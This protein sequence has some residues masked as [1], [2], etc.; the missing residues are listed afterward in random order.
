MSSS[1]SEHFS[2]KIKKNLF[3]AYYQKFI[4]LDDKILLNFLKVY[5]PL[6]IIIYLMPYV[7]FGSKGNWMIWDNLDSNY[8]W[9]KILLDSG[10][11]FYPNN[12]IIDQPLGGIPRAFLGSEPKLF[13][14]LYYF[15]GP[16][17]T[18]ILN[19][20]LITLFGFVGMYLLLKKYVI[21]D[22]E[23]RVIVYSVSLFF[24]ILPFWPPGGM[25]IAGI[26]LVLYKILKI[27]SGNN[28]FLNWFV[29]IFYLF[30]SNFFI[31]GFFFLCLLILFLLYDLFFQNTF[32][33]LLKVILVIL[34]INILINYRL[35]ELFIFQNE[36]VSN[37]TEHLLTLNQ[38]SLIDLLKSFVRR[39]IESHGHSQSLHGI[40]ILPIILM[41][42]FFML[43]KSLL[44][45][46][47]LLFLILFV[48]IIT[49][50]LN[51]LSF[52]PFSY[53]N[54]IFK[55]Y[56]YFDLARFTLL[57]PLF[58]MVAFALV[59]SVLKK[60]I[61]SS[62]LLIL[63]IIFLQT[64]LS[65]ANHEFFK[66]RNTPNINHFFAIEQFNEIKNFI[67]KPL[68]SYRVGSVGLEPS[69]SLYN[70]F[71]TIDGYFNNYPLSYKKKFRKII[72][73]ELNK[74][75][76]LKD[77]YDTNGN[78]VYLFNA[79]VGRA[80]Y[81][82]DNK[83]GNNVEIKN[84]EY[85]WDMLYDIGCRYILSAV[86]IDLSK[87]PYLIFEKK[88]VNEKSAWDIYLYSVKNLTKT[89]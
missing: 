40:F 72:S 62:S 58:W 6:I 69:I 44:E 66:N 29:I 79:Q 49:T 36:I 28:A 2:K 45:K 76:N 87:I 64:A 8:V 20:I 71:Y 50:T 13:Y 24:S 89:N 77:Y 52:P 84:L 38:D 17:F 59:L 16:E 19:R 46:Q 7:L 30:Y 12:S 43:P 4:L 75:S 39:L 61:N 15:F 41:S 31:F 57:F 74:D 14:L 85:D 37:R 82:L 63:N 80:F 83:A 78:R 54:Y 73:K 53:I 35:I 22:K 81:L 68:N 33:Q 70:G 9:I 27:R 55:K 5:S 11:I 34:F 25:S 18:Y 23:D 42:F 56:L 3:I 60:K 32:K 26:P 88:F 47:K 65:F 86:K 10:K 48:L 1:K 67:N 21:P 51:D